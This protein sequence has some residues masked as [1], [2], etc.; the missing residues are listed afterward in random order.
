MHRHAGDVPQAGDGQQVRRGN[1]YVTSE[2]LY[3]L[4]GGKA[5]GW[6]PQRMHWEGDT[7]CFLRHSSGL[8]LDATAAQFDAI[9]DYTQARGGGFLTAEPSRRAATLMDRL[10]YQP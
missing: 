10:L 4:L 8:T 9:P 1:C 2:A 3:H 7:H 5:A 6:T